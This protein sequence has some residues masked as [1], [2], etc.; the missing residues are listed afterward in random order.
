MSAVWRFNLSFRFPYTK[1]INDLFLLM[2]GAKEEGKTISPMP[3][4]IEVTKCPAL[5]ISWT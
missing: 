5:S 1:A 2:E 4:L 3:D